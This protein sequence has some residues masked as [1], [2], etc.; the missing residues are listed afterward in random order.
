MDS[1]LLAIFAIRLKEL[2]IILLKIAIAKISLSAKMLLFKINSFYGELTIYSTLTWR[3]NVRCFIGF[4]N[5]NAKL[6]RH[7]YLTTGA[8]KYECDN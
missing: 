1:H 8:S 2:G 3:A 6:G 7:F 4:C 5:V